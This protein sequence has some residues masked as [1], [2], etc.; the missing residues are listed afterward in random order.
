M[1]DIIQ[2][3]V[4]P[5]RYR[6]VALLAVLLIVMAV[7]VISLGILARST[8]ELA[9]GQNMALRVA[10]DQLA[11]S[12]LEHARGL[13]LNPQ[14]LDLVELDPTGTYWAGATG[15][16]DED[17]D[18]YYDVTV[19]R[20]ESDPNDL[21]NYTIQSEAYRLSDDDKI[22]R[23]QLSASLRLD[24]AIGLWAGTSTSIPPGLAIYGDV[25]C[26]GTLTNYGTID[27]DVF[28]NG[29][30][31]TITGQSKTTTDLSLT[32]P[33]LAVVDFTD[34]SHYTV[35][36]LSSGTLSSDLGP[37]APA[38]V[39]HRNGDLTVSDAVTVDGMLLVDGD[40]T[41]RGNDVTLSAAK[42][43]PAVYVTG[44]L[45]V[46][47]VDNL[48]IAGLVAVDGDI[49]VS[50]GASGIRVVG[51][52]FL[53]GD[54]TETIGDSSGNDYAYLYGMPAWDSTGGVLDGALQFDGVDD[55]IEVRRE[56]PFDI[57][58][59]ITI[60]A[61]IRVAHFDRS[62]QAI[63]TKGDDAW[64]IQR[65]S[66]TGRIEFA[67]TGLSHNSPHGSLPGNVRVDD[68]LWH[69][70]A[71]VYDGAR[72]FLYVDG[73]LDVS[74]AATG[75]IGTNNYTVRIGGNAEISGRLW[76]GW[77]DDVRIYNRGL[78]AVEIK[79]I[80][81][82]GLVPGLVARWRLDE[83]GAGVTVAADPARAALVTWAGG[84]RSSWSPAAG[85]FFKAI[86]R[87]SE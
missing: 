33:S 78:N 31:G 44:N 40:L 13:T 19:E 74:A 23:S 54:I 46:E 49:R 5:A 16:L 38:R 52:V 76:D 36:T 14:D 69:H 56:S 87:E 8:T 58:Q 47:D 27:G 4:S 45:V 73:N 20:D 84:M 82:G 28:S 60:A 80:T 42:N 62:Y 81:S 57:T 37:H 9:S 64:R 66:N 72:V 53:R 35:Q 11:A 70:V 67:C 29:L 75:S 71:G 55:Y 32:W 61:W 63:L 51:G 15:Q 65:W 34:P 68:G 59:R 7:T 50:A 86:D 3:H 83:S 6:G 77:I 48:A 25:R 1:S 17:S 30:T 41:I 43:M 79:S 21:C 22:G 85:A 12:G 2:H 26:G 18:D 39:F 10:M 24:P